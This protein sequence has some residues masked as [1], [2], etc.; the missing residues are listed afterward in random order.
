LDRA[1]S[2]REDWGTKGFSTVFRFSRTPALSLAALI[3][4]LALPYPAAAATTI[5]TPVLIDRATADVSA[6]F[7][8]PPDGLISTPTP[9]T[10]I[11]FHN[12]SGQVITSVQFLLVRNGRESE[13][14]TD[15]GKFTPGTS[16]DHT[17]TLA[18]ETPVDRIV[19]VAVTFADGSRWEAPETR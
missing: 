8:G 6:A 3:A 16:I 17:F 7:V 12:T 13:R 4:A 1:P 11:N 2:R 18:S 5:Q 19:P 9:T 14:I 15:A 10:E